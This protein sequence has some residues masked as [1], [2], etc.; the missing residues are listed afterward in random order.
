MAV[1]Q[2][3]NYSFS[4]V[5]FSTAT[6]KGFQLSR[7]LLPPSVNYIM[8]MEYKQDVILI[9]DFYNVYIISVD[10]LGHSLVVDDINEL[11]AGGSICWA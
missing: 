6:F 1:V 4:L 3:E 5:A 11:E 2:D 9:V 10:S 8:N 7:M